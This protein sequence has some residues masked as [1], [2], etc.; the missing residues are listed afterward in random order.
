MKLN[1]TGAPWVEVVAAP[2]LIGN[3]TAKDPLPVSDSHS[4]KPEEQFNT[5]K[6]LIK[7]FVV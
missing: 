7:I 2:D 1:E 6:K 5:Q 4:L 3:W